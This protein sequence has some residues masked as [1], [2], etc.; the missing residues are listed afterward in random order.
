MIGADTTPLWQTIEKKI[1]AAQLSDNIILTGGMPNCQVL[2][3]MRQ[4]HIFIFTS[5]RGE[6]WGAVLN[7]AMGAGCACVASDEIGAVPYLLRHKKNGLIFKS[8]SVES[9]LESVAYLY[10]N[11]EKRKEYSQKAYSTIT[12]DWSADNAASRLVQLSESILAGEEI[13]F[14]EGP[15]SK[16]Y[17]IKPNYVLA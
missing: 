2:E 12:N 14:D 13:T 3:K 4:S 11:P 15:C 16:A 17:P 5:D 10:D 9:L 7:E 1:D 8:C 6:G